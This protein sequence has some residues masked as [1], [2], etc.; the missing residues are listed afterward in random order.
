MIHLVKQPWSVRQKRSCKPFVFVREHPKQLP[1]QKF[2]IS[3][4]SK[5]ITSFQ[6]FLLN[7][8]SNI[9]SKVISRNI[10][11]EGVKKYFRQPLSRKDEWIS[12]ALECARLS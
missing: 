7:S 4:F 2:G 12:E 10:F 3:C 6:I 1:V 8:V 11:S 5:E 9:H